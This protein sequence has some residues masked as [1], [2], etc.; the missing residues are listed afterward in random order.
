MVFRL[1]GDGSRHLK[2]PLVAAMWEKV[3]NVT[4]WLFEN[5]L[6]YDHV[7]VMVI[8]GRRKWEGTFRLYPKANVFSALERIVT[9]LVYRVCYMCVFVICLAR[10]N[11][12]AQIAL[13][14]RTSDWPST[15]GNPPASASVVWG[16]NF[17]ILLCWLLF[18]SMFVAVL[19][20]LMGFLTVL[21]LCVSLMTNLHLCLC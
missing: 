5:K 7:K 9:K 10:S 18:M 13:E 21:L 8:T 15:H 4:I 3:L 17:H 16:S 14:L 11:S 19:M 20:D 1:A 6:C 2:C 12:V